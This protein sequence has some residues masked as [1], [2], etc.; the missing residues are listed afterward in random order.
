MINFF[1]DNANKNIE[2]TVKSKVSEYFRE[3]RF[4]LSLL[5]SQISSMV[6]LQIFYVLLMGVFILVYINFNYSYKI[7]FNLISNNIFSF[8][9]LIKQ[10]M[11][12]IQ[13]VNK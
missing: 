13:N 6:S 11:L 10:T 8:K 5:A 7:C 12:S 2:C 4:S 3:K 1:Y 9:N